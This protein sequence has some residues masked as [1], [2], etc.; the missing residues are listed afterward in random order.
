MLRYAIQYFLLNF[1]T[2][3][4]TFMTYNCPDKFMFSYRTCK[5]GVKINRIT[6]DNCNLD[7]Y[8]HV[9][10]RVLWCLEFSND[11]KVLRN[12]LNDVGITHDVV[13]FDFFY[14][15]EPHIMTI[16]EGKRL[17]DGVEFGMSFDEIFDLDLIE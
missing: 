1:R 11:I 14:N 12:L 5:N 8:N 9:Y 6:C 3:F 10:H 13:R 17:I 16:R 15:G 4:H 2:I 7:E